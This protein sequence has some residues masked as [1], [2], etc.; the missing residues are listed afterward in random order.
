MDRRGVR[1]KMIGRRRRSAFCRGRSK[2]RRD[3]RTRGH[4]GGRGLRRVLFGGNRG[5][6]GVRRRREFCRR[7]YRTVCAAENR[8]ERC[9]R[10]GRREAR[11]FGRI[12]GGEI[13][14]HCGERR[15][16]G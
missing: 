10:R 2:F 9:R 13:A 14:D 3:C 8:D 6:R 1:W 7:F 16:G 15:G 5:L 11:E 4:G 12:G